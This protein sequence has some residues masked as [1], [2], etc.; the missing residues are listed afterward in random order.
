MAATPITK[1]VRYINPDV[2]KVYFVATMANYESPTRSELDA[3]TDL[4]REIAS[5]EGWNTESENVETPDLDSRFTSV[6]PGRI[7]AEDSSLTFYADR[8]GSDAR[9]LLPRDTSGYIVWM[10]GGDVPGSP[11]D[12]YPVRVS[13]VGKERSVEGDDAATVVINF[14]ITSE[15]AEDVEIPAA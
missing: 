3:G 6:I 14:A 11:M 12:I 10:D 9:A 7:S 15:P 5:T 1:S 4:T 8:T 13:S 2:S